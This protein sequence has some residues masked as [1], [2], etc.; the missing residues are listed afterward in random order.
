MD[1]ML[2]GR[3]GDAWNPADALL[4]A[5]EDPGETGLPES[6]ELDV[7]MDLMLLGRSGDA[8]NPVDA[9]LVAGEDSGETITSS[10]WML[11]S[12]NPPFLVNTQKAKMYRVA[13]REEA[14][15]NAE[16]T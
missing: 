3:S 11:S 5:G 1:L 16:I 15:Q 8:W 14:K 9:L 4:V 2:L 12:F 6:S 10:N 7:S 13:K